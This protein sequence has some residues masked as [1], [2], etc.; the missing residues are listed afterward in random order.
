[1]AEKLI[2]PWTPKTVELSYGDV[3]MSAAQN[4]PGSTLKAGGEILDAVMSP[5]DTGTALIKL[6]SGGLQ[7]IL[8]ESVVQFIDPEG[9]SQE[10]RE[11]ASAVGEYFANKYGG[12]ANIKHAVATDPA[13]V[14]MDIATV[15]TGGGAIVTKVG[16]LSKLA[17]IENAGKKATTAATYVDPLSLTVKGGSQVIAKTGIAAREVSGATTGVGGNAIGEVFDASR[18]GAKEGTGISRGTSGE[19]VTGA[20]RG[21]TNLDD[22]LP[23]AMRDLEVMKKKKQFAYRENELLWKNDNTI[24]QFDDIDKAISRADKMVMYNNTVKNPVGVEA[25]Q[26]I[27]AVVDEW[28]ANPARTHHT[29]EG[30]DALKQALY[31]IV[32]DVPI[33][34]GTAKAMAQNVYHSVKDTIVAQAPGYARAMKEY[35]EASEMIT[36]IQKTLSLPVGKRGSVDTAIRKLN[37][38]MRDNVNTNNGQRLK[39]GKELEIQGGEPFMST[40]AGTQVQSLMPKGI[41]GAVTPSFSGL[42]ALTGTIDPVTAATAMAASSP[43]VVGEVTN[44]LGYATGKLDKLPLPS[45]QGIQGL[46]ETLYQIQ[47]QQEQKRN[48]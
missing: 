25:L 33:A 10:S 30:L 29:P 9:K 32:E 17:Q 15:M 40:L 28:K 34:N 23:I 26:K 39:L 44:A 45:Y 6:M 24:L 4:L 11:M 20:M 22:V 43:R 35:G 41:Q 31:S 36:Q 42:G 8:P 38:L 37:S 18:E 1:M 21:A 5:I 14:L 2:S 3:A 47:S 48:N 27:R 7:N 19:A 46:M 12:E 13:S 16:K